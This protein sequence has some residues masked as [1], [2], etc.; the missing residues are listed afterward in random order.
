M[1][2]Y[3]HVIYI[4]IYELICIILLNN[5]LDYN[6]ETVDESERRYIREK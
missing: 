4:F 3:D 5:Y 2:F 6:E 1:S